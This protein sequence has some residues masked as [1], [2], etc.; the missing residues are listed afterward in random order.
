MKLSKKEPK[1]YLYWA[2]CAA[3]FAVRIPPMFVLLTVML[4]GENADKAFE[5]VRD[6]PDR[7]MTDVWMKWK[8]K[9][10]WERAVDAI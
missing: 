10:Y 4:I 1:Q 7:I 6:K 2:L 9:P 3:Y 5:W 8:A